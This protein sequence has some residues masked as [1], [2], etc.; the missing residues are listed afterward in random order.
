MKAFVDTVLGPL[1]VYLAGRFWRWYQRRK[2]RDR[3]AAR[4]EHMIA[5]PSIPVTDPIEA[6]ERALIEEQAPTVHHVA[7]SVR[8]SIPPMFTQS[9]KLPRLGS[10]HDGENDPAKKGPQ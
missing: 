10:Q 2:F 1:I 3:V 8:K 9:G 5:D 4:A 7:R 6:A